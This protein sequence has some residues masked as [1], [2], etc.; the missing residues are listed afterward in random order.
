MDFT[1]KK[2]DNLIDYNNYFNT[3]EYGK[4]FLILLYFYFYF[5]ST[6]INI[7]F[8]NT[9]FRLSCFYKYIKGYIYYSKYPVLDFTNSL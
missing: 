8:V 3:S 5:K 7:N 9:P 4:C 1:T 2:I 6:I